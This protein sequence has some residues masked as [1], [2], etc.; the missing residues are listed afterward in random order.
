MLCKPRHCTL[1]ALPPNPATC[2]LVQ[3][4]AGPSVFDV[5]RS[6]LSV[7]YECFASPLNA[8]FSRFGSAFPDVD[9]PFGSGGSFFR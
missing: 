7:G 1:A 9:A 8:H 2:L 3:A 5:L 4:A 6:Q